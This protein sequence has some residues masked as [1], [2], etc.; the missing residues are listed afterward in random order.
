VIIGFIVAASLLVTQAGE[1]EGEGDPE[2]EGEGEVG[3]GEGE[4]EGEGEDP[5]ASR[6]ED[7]DDGNAGVAFCDNGVPAF[8]VC[9]DVDV[10]DISQTPPSKRDGYE[11][12]AYDETYWDEAGTNKL[13]HAPIHDK[14]SKDELYRVIFFMHE[15]SSSSPLFCGDGICLET[16]KPTSLPLRLQGKLQYDLP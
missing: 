6:C 10:G 1:G 2:G 4:G 8:I 14:L 13:A 7:D 15:W 11:Q 9:S 16:P 12:V 3:A 5:C